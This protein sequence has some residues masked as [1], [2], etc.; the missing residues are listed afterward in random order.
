MTSGKSMNEF[1]IIKGA[2][3]IERIQKDSIRIY[4][5]AK[6][7]TLY[8]NDGHDTLLYIIIGTSIIGLII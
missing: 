5:V 6:F 3:I 8:A 7:K 2:H 1:A 4:D